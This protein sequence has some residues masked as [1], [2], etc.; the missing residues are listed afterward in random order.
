[1]SSDTEVKVPTTMPAGR[2]S[3]PMAVTTD[4][5]VG[6]WPSTRRKVSASGTVRRVMSSPGTGRREAAGRTPLG[7]AAPELD[8]SRRGVTPQLPGVE[9]PDPAAHRPDGGARGRAHAAGT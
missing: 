3:R 2:P 4:A 7:R 1:G 5:P 9:S 8:G 6:W